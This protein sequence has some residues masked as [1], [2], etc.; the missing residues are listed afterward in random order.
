ASS[1]LKGTGFPRPNTGLRSTPGLRGW[2]SF[3]GTCPAPSLRSAF[4]GLAPWGGQASFLSRPCSPRRVRLPVALGSRRPRRLV[5]PL[6]HLLPEGAPG[7]EGRLHADGQHGAQ[8]KSHSPEEDDP[9]VDG[10][11]SGHRM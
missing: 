10:K 8:E 5:A 4:S 2:V 3:T 9:P 6:R 11:Q 1:G 7:N